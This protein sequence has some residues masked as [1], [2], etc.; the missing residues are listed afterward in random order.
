[1]FFFLVVSFGLS[2]RMFAFHLHQINCSTAQRWAMVGICYADIV[3]FG[4]AEVGAG[5]NSEIRETEAKT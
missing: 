4:K 5:R 3:T 2:E 1:L